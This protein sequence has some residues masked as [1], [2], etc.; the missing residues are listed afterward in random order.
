MKSISVVK[1]REEEVPDLRERVKLEM[2]GSVEGEDVMLGNSEYFS[3][4]SCKM[5][6]LVSEHC[7]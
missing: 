1:N 4:A 7:M 5:L 3:P 6:I 2:T